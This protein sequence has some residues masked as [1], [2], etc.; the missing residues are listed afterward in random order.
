M[1]EFRGNLIDVVHQRIFAATVRVSGGKIVAIEETDQAGS[2][3]LLP[4]F[5]DAHVHI[6]S[7]ML[8]PAEF[9]RAAVQHGTVATVSDPHE[10]GNVLGVEGVRYMLKNA[11]RGPLKI[12]FGAPACVPATI[13]ETAGATIDAQQV[14][15][16]LDDQRI[17]YLS[18]MMNYPGVLAGDAEVLAKIQAALDR[19][20]PVDGHAPGVRGA[21][22]ARYFGR[23]ISTDH[24]CISKA[25]ALDKL[26]CGAKIL[27]REG[28]AA[29]NFEALYTL[30]D[31]FPQECMLCS[32]D[33]HPDELV[34]G[35]INVLVQRAVQ[36]GVE[37]MNVLR[38]ACVN[39][40]LHYGLDVGLLRV[41]DDADFIE[42]D[43][44]QDW[45]VLQ[46][47]I[48]GRSVI[49]DPPAS[50]DQVAPA[51]INKFA[52]TP[53]SPDQFKCRLPEGAE[54]V[55]VIQALDGELVTQRQI[56]P[57]AVQDGLAVADPQRDL[58]KLVVVSR[59]ETAPPAIAF[60]HNFGLQHGAIASS[61]A[62]DSHNIV[63]VGTNDDDL[64]QAV[65]LVIQAR[66]GL[67]LATGREHHLLALPVAGLMSDRPYPEVA[68]QYTRL[69]RRAKELGSCLRAPFMA[70]S[71]MALL[72]IPEI[73]LSDQGLFDGGRF[74]FLPLFNAAP[75]NEPPAS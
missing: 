19:G 73:K 14:A 13:F 66:G 47:V 37:L 71:F 61:V 3:F 58:L 16:L 29:R 63:A 72:V 1:Q 24:E 34:E 56:F 48:R 27:I 10:I 32:D 65:N 31:E 57:V 46:T 60:I 7:S 42:V 6:E 11:E 64:C 15:Q 40:V 54:T 68:E 53:L 45:N 9:S 67:A 33:K 74:E 49:G 51:A 22:A 55:N 26:R 8:T 41:G 28:S 39:P 20:K 18:E 75:Q 43:N 35:H 70:L 44:L 36:R 62:H 59:Y 17:C 4:G 12:F 50:A 5:V 30:L 38:A 25:E 2:N 21:D 23:G 52:A 69:D